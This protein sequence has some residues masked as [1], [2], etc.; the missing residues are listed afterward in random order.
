MTA[1]KIGV[2]R[3]VWPAGALLGEGTCWSPRE[4]A[5]WWVD[6]LGHRLLHYTPADGAQ[7]EWSFDETI[8]AVAERADAPGLIV[9]LRR[10][11]A[12][13]DPATGALQRLAEPEPERRSNRFN[14]GKC[15][16]AG[17]FWGGTMDLDC[18][19]P[20]G[21]LYRF[22]GQRCERAFDAGFAVTN[23][24]TWSLDG[25]TMYFNDT[26]R[27]QVFAI[28]FDAVD[29]SLGEPRPFL[30]FAKDDGFPDGMTT[31]A[32]GRLWIAHWG[33]SCVSCHDADDGRELARFV[34][35]VSQVTNVAFGGPGLATLYVSSARTGLGEAQLAAEPL[36]GGLFA[37]HTDATGLAANLFEG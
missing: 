36:A 27:R 10:G 11:F 3:C 25:R 31:D 37:V 1:P 6:I 30:R 12:Y 26:A 9:T 28:P 8:S 33:A 24:P 15:D 19:A 18:A 20:T 16:A 13:F 34:L 5:L 29:G 32:A 4:R 22:D 23:G 21:A 2:P 14:D 7:R 35:P 17:R